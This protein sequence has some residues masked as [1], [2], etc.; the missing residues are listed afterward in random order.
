MLNPNNTKIDIFSE[1][2]Y[3]CKYME[4]HWGGGVSIL[5]KNGITFHEFLDLSSCN[6]I[7]ESTFIEIE[8]AG[9]VLL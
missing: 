7:L 3:I 6:E 2:N 1:N 5:V 8:M 9:K 4:H